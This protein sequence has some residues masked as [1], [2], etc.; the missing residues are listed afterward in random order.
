[1]NAVVAVAARIGAFPIE[2]SDRTSAPLLTL[3]SGV[4][5]FVASGKAGATVIVLVEVY[6]AD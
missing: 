6:D 2:A 3:Q 1:M 5:S 4:Y